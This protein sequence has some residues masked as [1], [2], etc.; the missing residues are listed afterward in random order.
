M[1]I[2]DVK[3]EEG[4]PDN[5][6]NAIFRKQRELMR[7]YHPI[8]E[9]NGLLRTNMIPVNPHCKYGQAQLKDFAWRFTEEI[10]EATEALEIHPN[11]RSH[12]HEELIDALH[13]L[14]ELCILSEVAPKRIAKD[15]DE[16]EII[17]FKPQE[18]GSQVYMPIEELAKAMNCLKNKPWKQTHMLTDTTKYQEHIVRTFELFVN[19]LFL[20]GLNPWE[21]YDI[22]FKKNEV[23]KFRQRS[24]Y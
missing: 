4:Y 21:I 5:L 10:G 22:Y 7:F 15:L 8:E 3:S 13:F 17:V 18:I 16:I 12:F 1:N 19:V 2:E 9:R 11:N 14:V 24:K 20:V 6:L 23:N